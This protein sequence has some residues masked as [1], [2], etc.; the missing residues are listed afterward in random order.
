[1]KSPGVQLRA[2]QAPAPPW[3]APTPASH[4]D[5]APYHLTRR[6]HSSH[7]F[8]LFR[9]AANGDL[10]PGCYILKTPRPNLA[11]HEV[12][13]AMLHREATVTTTVKHPSLNCVLSADVQS[14]EPYLL[15]PY[16]DGISLRQLL[17]SSP[18]R[19]PVSRALSIVRQAV[20]ALAALHAAGWL[21][22]QVRPEHILLS[23]QG[24]VILI[25]LTLARR[26]E[27]AECTAT[28]PTISAAIYAPPET[29]LNP[30]LTAAAEIYSLGIVLFEI[31]A[32]SPPFVGR[33]PSELLA[34]H[35]RDAIPD[36]RALRSDIS[37]ETVHLLRLMLAKEPLRRPTDSDLLRWLAD[38]EIASL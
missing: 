36:I 8:D 24:G 6:L 17:Q 11:A 16:R 12:A 22:G 20:E 1:M 7:T 21:H 38:E 3:R 13:T 27:T 25:D 26:L 5:S 31:L 32:G 30:R 9:A 29:A 18:I 35:R 2:T 15:L 28:A 14:P 10:G 4:T 23:P 33:S 19:I 37:L 34:Q